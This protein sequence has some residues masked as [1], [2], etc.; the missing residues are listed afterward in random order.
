MSSLNKII[1][2]LIIEV[3]G[4][5]PEHLTKKLKEISERINEEKDVEVKD[6]KINDSKPMEKQKGYFV[7]FAEI[8]VEVKNLE[9]LFFLV[10]KYLP[11][12]IE[13]ISPE[14]LN[15]ENNDLNT[16]LNEVSRKFHQY[17]HVARVL[18][19]EKNVLEK[20][21]KALSDPKK[22]SKGK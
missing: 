1:S 20:K 10:I 11:A 12:H 18:Q 17:D 16:P 3:I 6:K 22:E 2:T 7:N 13:I 15:L 5:P 21:F 4:K 14:K 8:E 19:S 9:R